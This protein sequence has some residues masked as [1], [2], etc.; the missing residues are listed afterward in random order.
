MIFSK[1]SLL[2]TVKIYVPNYEGAL[3]IYSAP[4]AL[5]TSDDLKL[6]RSTNLLM[7]KSNGCLNAILTN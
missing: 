3:N 6:R 7:T 2:P 5:N 4:P 1:R